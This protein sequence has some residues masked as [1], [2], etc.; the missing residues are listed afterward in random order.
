MFA[1]MSHW[2]GQL[3][4]I[5]GGTMTSGSAEPEASSRSAR[6]AACARAVAAGRVFSAAATVLGFA[7]GGTTGHEGL[8]GPSGNSLDSGMDA[9]AT[10]GDGAGGDSSTLDTG[11][12]DVQI[13]YANPDR[14]LPETNAP[15]E[16]AETEAATDGGGPPWDCPPFIGLN[17]AGQ[18]AAPGAPLYYQIPSEYSDAGVIV[19]AP[20]G[21]VC[22]SYPWLGSTSVDQCSTTKISDPTYPQLPPC[23]WCAEAG[24]AAAGT[25]AGTPRYAVCQ[26]LYD[27]MIRTGCTRNATKSYCLCGDEDPTTCANDPSPPGPCA[28]WEMGAFEV[29]SQVAGGLT[30]AILNYTD[31][32]PGDTYFCAGALN[33]IMY[34]ATSNCL[35]ADDAGTGD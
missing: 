1:E 14:L 4:G 20:D 8:E 29:S 9:D 16:D 18:P 32:T 34:T 25:Y 6:R 7:C 23:N 5:R 30:A 15:P 2:A 13:F 10:V 26:G 35:P 11:A 3:A 33:D 22:A 28:G 27:C 21:S 12:F 17:R 24:A 19:P 31:T